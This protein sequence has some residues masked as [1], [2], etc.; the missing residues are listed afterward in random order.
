MVW[1]ALVSRQPSLHVC[2]L[3]LYPVQG[4]HTGCKPLVAL[5]HYMQDSDTDLQQLQA[6]LQPLLD[7][8]QHLP[9]PVPVACPVM[10][11]AER[12]TLLRAQLR[13]L[14]DA[15]GRTSHS[16]GASSQQQQQPQQEPQQQCRRVAHLLK[17]LQLA[18]DTLSIMEQ[19]AGFRQVAWGALAMWYRH[20][21]AASSQMILAKVVL[22]EPVSVSAEHCGVWFVQG[23]G[24][25]ISHVFCSCGAPEAMH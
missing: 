13:E 2:W 18:H 9:E 7:A 23:A 25:G 16:L 8:E 20:A 24:S 3:L 21:A 10:S 4:T 22:N 5:M 1:D 11:P 19:H 12:T 6:L 15:A 14:K 17:N